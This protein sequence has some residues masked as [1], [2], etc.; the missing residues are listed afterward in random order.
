MKKKSNLFRGLTS[1]FLSLTVISGVVL[2]VGISWQGRVN[3]LLGIS[4]SA[5]ARSEDPEDYVYRSDYE[6]PT[7]LIEDKIAFNTRMQAE[8]SV[9][10]KGMPKTDGKNVTLFGMRSGENMQFGGTMGAVIDESN[11]VT[12]EQALTENGFSVNPATTELFK[13][14]E[15]LDEYEPLKSAGGNVIDLNVGTAVNEIP[16]SEYEGLSYDGYQDA[17]IIVLGR[18]AGES[19]CFYP[20]AEGTTTF[21][22][23]DKDYKNPIPSDEFANSPTGNILSLSDDERE[24]I[25][26]VKGLGFKKVE[27]L[28]N[29]ACAMEI[30]ELKTDEGVDSILWIGNPGAY[31]TYGIAKLLS[32]EYLPSGHLPDTYAVNSA[33]SPAMQN[34]GVYLFTNADEID[35]SSNNALRSRWYL[36]ENEGIYTGYKYYETRYFDCITGQGNA[37]VALKK[38]TTDGSSEWNY[39]KEVSYPFGFGL[40]GSTFEEEITDI[41]IDWSGE[42]ESKAVVKVK[43]TGDTEAKHAIQLYVSQPYTDYDKA[44][45]V[46]KAA[47]QL[48]AFGKT[49]EAEEETFHDYVTLKPGKTEE[50]ELTFNASDILSY[51][52]T[53]KHDGTK[54]AY[55]LEKGDYFFATGNSAHDAV[56]SGSRR[57]GG[58]RHLYHFPRA[59]LR[60]RGRY[61]GLPV[62]GTFPEKPDGNGRPYEYGHLPYTGR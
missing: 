42:E 51:D 17:A 9:A 33:L 50:V 1:I 54:G 59:E 39:D 30:E 58:R 60:K 20:G 24:L 38:E 57:R 55:L 26:Y 11:I 53:Y 14:K 48:V 46:E 10:L 22:P 44:N 16:V 19:A 23:E 61:A 13:K 7:E 6:N 31:G 18:D 43:N 41:D 49:G 5:F 2:S 8:G 62:C 36:M 29:S 12:L 45:G 56:Q 3:E 37:S 21:D 52:S 40:E 15:I 28:L 35:T 34:Y 4:D 32:G 47:V 27:V 25:Y